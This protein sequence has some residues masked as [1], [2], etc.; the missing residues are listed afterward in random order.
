MQNEALIKCSPT[1]IRQRLLQGKQ[2]CANKANNVSIQKSHHDVS[3]YAVLF[4]RRHA[5][6]TATTVRSR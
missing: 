6:Q 5:S 2:E 1:K 3:Y 4:S